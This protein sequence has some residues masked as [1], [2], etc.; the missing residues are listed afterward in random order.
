MNRGKA[1]LMILGATI[2]WGTSYTLSKIGIGSFGVFNL[3]A[4]RFLLGFTVSLIALRRYI[5]VGKKTLFYSLGLGSVLFMAFAAMTLALRYTTASNVGF[6]TGSLVI[7]VPI[8]SAL[9]FREKVERKV[10]GGSLSALLGIGLITLDNELGMNRGDILALLGAIMFALHIVLTGRFTKKVNSISL[11]V[12]QLSI[13]G[14]LSLVVSVVSEGFHLPSSRDLWFIVLF[15]SLIC[16]AFGYIAQTVAQQAASSEV[17]GLLISLEPLFSAITAYF[18]LGEVMSGR[19][20][21]G[22]VILLAS[23]VSVQVDP[24]KV[25]SILLRE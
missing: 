5:E 7:I 13:V 6:L 23:V 3:I 24:L 25:K 15:L 22:G 8:I 21:W 2:F 1:N 18:V 9:L 10:L 17:T 14:I 19:S 11:G 16:T 20:V 12:L 4:I